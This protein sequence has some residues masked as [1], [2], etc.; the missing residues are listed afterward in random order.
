MS[1]KY[2]GEGF[3]IHTG[4]ID[5]QFPHHEAEIAQ[6]EAAGYKFAR[7]WMHHN[8]VLLG[9]EKMAKS[10]GNFVVLRDLLSRHEPITVRFYLLG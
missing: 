3:D 6:A 1:L 8:H 5:L 10:T 4:G 2:L 7:Y 9:G